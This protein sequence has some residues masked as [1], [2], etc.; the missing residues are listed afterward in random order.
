MPAIVKP[1]AEPPVTKLPAN[2]AHGS[3]DTESDA[4]CI[5]LE[6]G[7]RRQCRSAATYGDL[8]T[9]HHKMAVAGNRPPI[10]D[11]GEDSAAP[12][13]PSVLDGPAAPASC[14]SASGSSSSL[15][16]RWVA[17]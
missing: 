8:C 12:G 14:G 17:G 9:K 4:I 3:T 15:R 2:A 11:C 10:H 1:V 13:S 5:A 16:A 6:R 7:G